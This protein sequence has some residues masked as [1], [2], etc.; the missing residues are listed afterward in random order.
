MEVKAMEVFRLLRR[1][2]SIARFIS[3]LTLAQFSELST[4]P[5]H[6]TLPIQHVDGF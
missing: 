6:P 4:S 2:L 3:A 5:S 1:T